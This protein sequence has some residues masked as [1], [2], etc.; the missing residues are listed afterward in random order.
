MLIYAHI[1]EHVQMLCSALLSSSARMLSPL[2]RFFALA[3]ALTL[4]LATIVRYYG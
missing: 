3:Q 2:S 4:K 1:A